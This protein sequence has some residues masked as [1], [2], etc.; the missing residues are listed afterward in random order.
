VFDMHFTTKERSKGSGLGLTLCRFIMTRFGGSIVLRNVPGG[1]EAR[2]VFRRAQVLAPAS[3]PQPVSATPV[4]GGAP[5]RASA[6][7]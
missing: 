7:G 6:A 3:P 5:M 1:A 4:P 2:L